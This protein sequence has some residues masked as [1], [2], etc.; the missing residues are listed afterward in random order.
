[1]NELR[2]RIVTAQ[3][4][5]PHARLTWEGGRI[6]GIEELPG[7]APQE[8]MTVIPGLVD[9]HNHGGFRGAFPTG[10]AEEC[11]RAVRF[12]RAQGTTTMLASLVSGTERELSRQV[13]VLRELV[14]QGELQG[15]H[16]EG[17]FINAARCGAQAPSRIQPGDPDMLR[18]LVAASKSTV[19][20]ITFA[21][22]TARARELVEVCA[23]YGII[24]SLGHTDAS[25]EEVRGI[26]AYARDR[27]VTV[28]ATHLFNGMPPLH[29]RAPGPVAALIEAAARG[30]AWVE[31]IADGVHLSDATVD[32]VTAA[33]PEHALAV[34]D[35]MEAAGMPDGEYQLGPLRVE[36]REAV[37]RLRTEGGEPGVI[38][39][40]TSTLARQFWNYQRRHGAVA[41]VRLTSAHAARV[42]GMTE[43]A[44]DL[45]GGMPATF[46][47]LDAQGEVAEVWRGGERCRDGAEESGAEE[48]GQAAR[49]K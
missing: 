3:R 43:S 49:R 34:T 7:P 21:P 14:E 18:R 26:L 41:A 11:L 32:M 23:E 15:I 13:G 31:L 22:E 36:V 19:R 48:S 16:L 12:H 9:L 33:A 27:G 20:Q 6:A 30:E 39:G 40:G 44:G 5:Y 17:P 46:V 2:G 25:A 38:A 47:A 8:A 24:A 29:H 37:A 35:A 1:M 42:L 10:S 45:R 4:E 28:T